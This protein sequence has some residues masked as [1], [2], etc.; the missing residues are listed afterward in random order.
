[1]EISQKIILDLHNRVQTKNIWI[2]FSLIK[3]RLCLKQ[4]VINIQQYVDFI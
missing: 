3:M 4:F 2:I 1:M